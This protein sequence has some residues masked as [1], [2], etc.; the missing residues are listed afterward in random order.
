MSHHSHNHLQVPISQFHSQYYH[1][2]NNNHNNHYLNDDMNALQSTRESLTN[3][4]LFVTSSTTNTMHTPLS[5]CISAETGSSHTLMIPSNQCSQAGRSLPDLRTQ[6]VHN[7]ELF[8]YSKGTPIEMQ[9]ILNL[10]SPDSNQDED[11]F[12]LVRKIF[13]KQTKSS[14]IISFQK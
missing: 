8:S 10:A 13:V 5:H 14:Y 4:Q 11:V 7:N 1:D 12:V 6:N 2:S 9:Q 3:P